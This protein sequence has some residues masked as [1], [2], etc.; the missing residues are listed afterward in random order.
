MVVDCSRV[1]RREAERVAVLRFE[2]LTS[3]PSLDWFARALSSLIAAQASGGNRWSALESPDLREAHNAR[4]TQIVQ[5]YVTRDARGLRVWAAVRD[6]ESR[7]NVRT[8]SARGTPEQILETAESLAGQLAPS[9]REYTTRNPA[10]VQALFSGRVKDAVAADPA[11]G[12]AQIEAAVEAWRAGDRQT[13]ERCLEAAGK[14]RLT[15]AERAR[16]G[17]LQAQAGGDATAKLQA[18]KRLAGTTA[19]EPQMWRT[20]AELELQFKQFS[21]AAASFSRLLALSPG[22]AAALNSQ[23]YA[24]LFSG[25]VEGALQSAEKYRRAAPDSANT[26]D[27]LGEI[28][29][30]RRSYSEAARLFTEAHEKDP[31]ILAG[32]EPFRAALSLYLGGNAAGADEAFERF[33]A[34]RAK[35]GDRAVTAHR[36]VWFRLTGRK[37]P[38]PGASSLELADAALWALYDG[39]RNRAR[40]LAESARAAADS[41]PLVYLAATTQFLAQPSAPAAEW[42]TRAAKALA[43]PEQAMLRKQWLGL[44]LLLDRRYPEAARVWREVY[45]AT[46]GLASF[47]PRIALEWALLA[48]GDEAGANAIAPAGLLPPRSTEPGATSLLYAKALELHAR[49]R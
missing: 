32:F 18:L 33:L 34:A 3:D 9:V 26:L 2:N 23:A 16:L 1:P 30:W 21:D 29:F 35:A 14:A 24:R 42:E 6:E 7:K 43:R 25:D 28:H 49:R 5:G 10:A 40:T 8:I 39:D 15:E 38:A 20:V 31:G 44:A 22:D 48:S 36:S 12:L 47:E 4:A 37:P 45:D 11:W 13:F 41:P 46:P 19:G 27:T 17:V